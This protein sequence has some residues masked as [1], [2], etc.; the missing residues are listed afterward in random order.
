MG[1]HGFSRRPMMLELVLFTFLICG[2]LLDSSPSSHGEHAEN[3]TEQTGL[4]E[5]TESVTVQQAERIAHS[6]HTAEPRSSVVNITDSLAVSEQITERTR[7]TTSSY[8]EHAE[9]KTEQTGLDESTE[10]VTVQQAERI[11]HSEHTAEPRSS[12]VNITDS[13]AVSEQITERTRVTTSSHGEH[14][15]NKTEQTG[16]D[17][18][19]ES[20]TV[21]QAERI[22]HSEHTAEPR[23]SVVNITDSLAVSEQITERTRVTTSSHGEHA[24]NKTEQT[25]LDESTESVTVQQA[26]RIAHSEH[27]AEPRSSVVNITDSLA[28]SEQITERTRVTTSSYG[29]HA[30]NKTEQTGLDESTESVTVQQAERIAHS[31]HT[32]EP[33]SSVV[34]ITDSLAVSEQITERT[35]VT[36]SSHGEHAENKTEQ[37]GLDES[38]ESVTVQQAERIAHS[39]HTAEPRSSVVNITDSLAV[40]EQITERTRV[41]TSSHGEHAENKTEQTG[42]DEST[43][44][45]TVQQA[46]RIAHSEHTAEPRSSVVNIT[47]SLAVS[48]QITERTRVTTSSYGE[49][50]ENKTEQTGLDESTESVTVQQAERIAHSEHTAEPR[51]SVVNITDSLAVSEQITERTRV[52]TSSYGEHAE[53]KTEQTGLDESTESVTVQQAERIAHSEHTAEPRSSVVNITDSLAV[54]E[55]IT[56]RT[57]VTISSYKEQRTIGTKQTVLEEKT[58]IVTVR[59]TGDTTRY[60]HAPGP[61]PGAANVANDLDTGKIKT[62]KTR[63]SNADQTDSPETLGE[64]SSQSR[65]PDFRKK[66]HTYDWT[67]RVKETGPENWWKKYP[68]AKGTRQS[69]INIISSEAVRYT[70]IKRI[71]IFQDPKSANGG[72]FTLLNT[73]KNVAV[74]VHSGDWFISYTG[75]RTKQYQI[76]E[77]RFHWGSEEFNGAERSIDGRRFAAEAQLYGFNRIMHSNANEEFS[78]PDALTAIVFFLEQNDRA[79]PNKTFFGLLGVPSKKIGALYR[80]RHTELPVDFSVL[81]GLLEHGHYYAYLGSDTIPRCRENIMWVINPKPA[82][83]NLEE[84]RAL[85]K[86][87]FDHSEP[88]Y[89]QMM[90]NTRPVFSLNPENTLIPRRVY[91]TGGALLPKSRLSVFI[92]SLSLSVPSVVLP[93]FELN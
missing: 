88:N 50:A 54:S 4:D 31:E 9:N 81:E 25:G 76:T 23:S 28:V 16:L 67:Y 75:E 60:E 6:E 13:L 38:T 57:R 33:R 92:L 49:H 79:G 7:V 56:E 8:G 68:A 74:R 73:G 87:Y 32:A 77:L 46:E 41:T 91:V 71:K 12:V 14:A 69:P 17:E 36:T 86:T 58:A 44:S 64:S 1:L 39:E 51:S 90:N 63:I 70:E 34:N 29:E 42:L 35:R 62:K 19:T 18:S 83:I 40:S 2:T 65:F 15:E 53:N 21:Q 80:Y 22:A 72:V 30:E 43:E 55:Q 52:T 27:T 66:N 48:E 93:Y 61:K 85:R 24:E 26:E 82:S 59:S 45:V 10:S 84:L 11:A 47:D 20:V 89:Q 5:S 37:T 78:S 3:K